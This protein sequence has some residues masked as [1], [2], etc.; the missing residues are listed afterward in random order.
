MTS[1]IELQT[2][3]VSRLTGDEYLMD[4]VSGIYDDVP[5]DAESPY[6]VVGEASETAMNTFNRKGR[7]STLT[8]HIY[9]EY[10]GFKEGL[11]ILERLTELLDGEPLT[12]ATQHLVHLIFDNVQTID[13]ETF[14]HLPVTFRA[15]V[16]E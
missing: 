12:L 8:I 10:E 16:Q 7:E 2:A 3:I 11:R 5:Q 13:G 14:K 9:S 6:V 15:V 1:L 4:I